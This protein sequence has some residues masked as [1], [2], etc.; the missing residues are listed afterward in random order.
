MRYFKLAIKIIVR[1]VF[2]CVAGVALLLGV[3]W[4]DHTRATDLPEPSGPFRSWPNDSCPE[5][6]RHSGYDVAAT[7][8]QTRAV[9]VDLVSGG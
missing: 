7:R 1:F 3:L 9:R 4:L 5:R 2:V 8:H 6:C